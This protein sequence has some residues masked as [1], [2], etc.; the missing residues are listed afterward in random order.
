MGETVTIIR[1]TLGAV[2]DY[3]NP[4]FTTA[5]VTVAGCLVGWGSTNEPVT[6]EGSPIDTQMTLY[7]PAGSTVQDEDIFVVRGDQFVKDGMAQAWSSML[8]VSKGVVVSLRRR[9]G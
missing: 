8:N 6:A 3:G 4:T 2:D 1:R 7:M 5:E 9:D